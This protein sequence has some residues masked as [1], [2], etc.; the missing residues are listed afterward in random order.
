MKTQ[1]I[2]SNAHLLL[3]ASNKHSDCFVKGGICNYEKRTT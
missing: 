1:K 2:L 3:E